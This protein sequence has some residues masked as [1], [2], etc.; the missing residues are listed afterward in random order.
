M[1]HY[2]N[3]MLDIYTDLTLQCATFGGYMEIMEVDELAALRREVTEYGE[4]G[5]G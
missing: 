5:A 1:G 4:Q 2:Y 3:G